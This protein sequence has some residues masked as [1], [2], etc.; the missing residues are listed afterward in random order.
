MSQ[1]RLTR[2][3]VLQ[4]SGVAIVSGLA[5]CGG[6]GGGDGDGDGDSD[7]GGS[8]EADETVTVGGG[9]AHFAPET[10]EISAGQTVAWEGASP[11]H[12]IFVQ[13]QPD[14]SDWGGRTNE[15][16]DDG[17]SYTHTFETAGTYTYTCSAY[18]SGGG[19]VEVTE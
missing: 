4:A 16:L 2:R 5:G 12:K 1:E 6:G 19:T 7:D 10:V 8:V 15:F 3:R 14:G 11:D 18:H 13:E 9:D 17:E